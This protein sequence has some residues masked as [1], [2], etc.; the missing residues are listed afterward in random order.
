ML[1][2]GSGSCLFV[3]RFG[4]RSACGGGVLGGDRRG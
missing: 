1:V 4:G 2:L 3:L